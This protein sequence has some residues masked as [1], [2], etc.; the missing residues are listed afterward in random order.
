[1]SPDHRGERAS[2]VRHDEV[3]GNPTTFRTR[4]GDVVDSGVPSSL[5]AGFFDVKFSGLIVVEPAKQI[6]VLSKQ[7][8]STNQQNEGEGESHRRIS[9]E[10]VA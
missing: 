5:N 1:M 4:V 8:G 2:A 10:N 3:G 9:S 6:R 7:R